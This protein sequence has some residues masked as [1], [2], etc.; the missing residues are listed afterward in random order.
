M[1]FSH[2]WRTD[3]VRALEAKVGRHVAHV[4]AARPWCELCDV[5]LD[6]R[7][8][9][10]IL[11]PSPLSPASQFCQVECALTVLR[12]LADYPERSTP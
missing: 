7:G 3:A 5:A 11:T 12:E 8:Y 9:A 2:Y 4:R 1:Q 10:F 6:P